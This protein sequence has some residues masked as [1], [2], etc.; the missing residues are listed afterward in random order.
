MIRS[1]EERVHK[2]LNKI[3]AET[4]DTFFKAM[5]RTAPR[6]FEYSIFT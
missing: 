2:N 1:F 6:Y 3:F 5:R 4:P